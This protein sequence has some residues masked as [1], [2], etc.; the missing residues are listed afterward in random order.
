[1]LMQFD[2]TRGVLEHSLVADPLDRRLPVRLREGVPYE[3]PRAAERLLEERLVRVVRDDGDPFGRDRGEPAGMIEVRVRVDDVADRLV[4][5]G[6]LHFR[7][8]RQ[9]ARFVLSAFEHDDV[10][11]DL[12]GE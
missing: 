6:L 12:D 1:M 10:V 7:Q 5:N 4:R 2:R 3:R 8:D 11:A 9:A